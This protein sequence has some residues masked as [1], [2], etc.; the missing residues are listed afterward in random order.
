MSIFDRYAFI[1]ET[2]DP[3]LDTSKAGTSMLYVVNAIIVEG[4]KLASLRTGA[5]E[6]RKKHFQNGPMKSAKVANDH[7]RRIRILNDLACLDFIVFPV[8]IDKRKLDGES[9]LRWTSSF[10]KYLHGVLDSR[11]FRVYPNLQVISDNQGSAEFM[12]SFKKYVYENYIP[13]LFADA[14]FDFRPSA[15]EVLLQ[16]ADFVGG[17]ISKCMDPTVPGINIDEYDK[18][19]GKLTLFPRHW[20]PIAQRLFYERPE[21]DENEYEHAIGTM[22]LTQAML[23]IEERQGNP[24]PL[25]N[26]QLACLE[27]LIM[28]ID[29]G[30]ADK[31]VSAREL[32]EYMCTMDDE[33][34]SDYSFRISV[35]GPLRDHG[36]MIASSNKGYKLPTCLTDCY[37]FTNKINSTVK[38]YLERLRTFSDNVFIATNR[39]VDMLDKVEYT[40]LR[41][42]LSCKTHIAS[43]DEGQEDAGGE[44]R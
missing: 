12:D 1:D 37:E 19:L 42:A 44:S 43:G 40:E 4:A 38:P 21:G 23:F 22:A 25:V 35:I 39:E 3:G 17:T 33:Y 30:H 7:G 11:L 2:G 13:H 18:I 36:V 29:M 41:Q 20:P 32:R 10:K 24:D 6:V 34:P 14:S 26:Q 31:Y 8:I 27:Y 5:D 28:Q 9:G 15:T 16:V